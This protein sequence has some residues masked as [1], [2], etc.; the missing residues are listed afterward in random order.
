MF[1]K[2]LNPNAE[3]LNKSAALHMNINAAKGLQDVL[4]TNFGPKGTI[5]MNQNVSMPGKNS[6]IVRCVA[7]PPTEKTSYKTQVSRDENLAKLQAGYLFPEIGRRRSAHMLKHPDAK[8]ISLG[9]GDTTEPIPEFITSAMAQR[10]H[11]L[12][13]LKG[14]SVYGAEQGEKVTLIVRLSSFYTNFFLHFLVFFPQ[15]HCDVLYQAVHAIRVETSSYCNKAYVDSSVIICQTG[16]FQKDVEKYGNIAYMRC[17]PENDFFPDLSSV[18]RTDI[19]FFC[20]PNNPTGAAASREQLTKL[21]QFAKDNGSIIVYDSAYAMYTCDDSPKSIFE[22]PGAKESGA[23][24][25]NMERQDKSGRKRKK[26]C[27]AKTNVRKRSIS[28]SKGM[29]WSKEKF[30]QKESTKAERM[31]LKE[32]MH[33][34]EKVARFETDNVM[35]CLKN[36][37]ERINRGKA[38]DYKE[39]S[40]SIPGTPGIVQHEILNN[41]RH[42]LTKIFLRLGSLAVHLDMPQCFSDEMYSADLNIPGKPEDDKLG[43]MPERN[44]FSWSTMISRYSQSVVVRVD[45][46]IG[47]CPRR[48]GL[49]AVVGGGKDGRAGVS[50]GSKSSSKAS[51]KRSGRGRREAREDRLRVGSWNIGTLQG[52]SVEL[53]KILKKRRISIASRNGV[54]ILVD[55]EL[56]GQVVEVKRVSDRLMTIQLVIGGFTLIVCSVYAPQVGLEEEVNARFWEALDEVV[57]SV[58]SSENIIITGDFNGQIGVILGGYE[59]MHGGFGFGVRIKKVE[60]KKGVYVKLI[61]SKD[62]EKKR[63]NWEVYKVARKEAKLAGMVTKTATFESLYAG[64][65]KKSEEK[66]MY[67]LAKAYKRKGCDLDQVKYIKGEDGSVLVEGVHIKKRQQ[68]YFYRL[69]NEEGGRG[70][71]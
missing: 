71:E 36:I 64:L 33:R 1:V 9:I 46:G 58:P 20:S 55:K 37:S 12:S 28:T 21:V 15:I 29:R 44:E 17:T 60:I 18:P 14:Y 4:K 50:V 66:R 5:K 40:L 48:L 52:K 69:L 45:G 41:R 8:I 53:V 34:D 51:S 23:D 7:T 25:K 30:L 57:R 43:E 3:L 22:I 19:I 11:E 38:P 31:R 54:G 6:G 63:V 61:E 62:G 35:D 16:Q 39:P 10:A 2:V 26:N 47:S 42:V 24:E 67:R 27:S 49:G 68:E 65:E 59:D 32:E 56:R 13:T 70:I